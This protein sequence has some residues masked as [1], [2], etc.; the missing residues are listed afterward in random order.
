VL[1][2]YRFLTDQISDIAHS[3]AEHQYEGSSPLDSRKLF[4]ENR[5]M[6]VK[7]DRLEMQQ[8]LTK[9]QLEA[10]RK[11]N[12]DL[13]SLTSNTIAGKNELEQFFLECINEVKKDI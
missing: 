5:F 1:R 12:R 9:S 4:E 11:E 13:R 6:K 7:L 2:E 3:K 8:D 10:E